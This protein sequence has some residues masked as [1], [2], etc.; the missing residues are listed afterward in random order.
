[1][2]REVSFT[3]F[4]KGID[5]LT[6]F[7]AKAL[8]EWARVRWFES[9]DE[10]AEVSDEQLVE[11]EINPNGFHGS[12]HDWGTAVINGKEVFLA[13]SDSFLDLIDFAHE[14]N[15]GVTFVQPDYESGCLCEVAC[16]KEDHW[17]RR[18]VDS[19]S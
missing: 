10:I 13:E 16:Y 6:S 18:R 11:E 4:V 19:Q 2:V 1:M 8:P 15:C 9:C 14:Y 12:L 7:R 17:V 5:G 3:E